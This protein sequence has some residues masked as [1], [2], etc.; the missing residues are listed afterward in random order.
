MLSDLEIEALV[1]I[2]E[3]CGFLDNPTSTVDHG[4]HR[5]VTSIKRLDARLVTED[6]NRLRH[7]AQETSIV[8]FESVAEATRKEITAYIEELELERAKVFDVA[9]QFIDSVSSDAWII[10]CR[11][12]ERAYAI[13]NQAEELASRKVL[14]ALDNIYCSV[15]ERELR[16]SLS[17]LS[18]CLGRG[19]LILRPDLLDIVDAANGIGRD[20]KR[21]SP[22][23]ILQQKRA[24]NHPNED[25]VPDVSVVGSTSIWDA[26][27]RYE[28]SLKSQEADSVT[29]LTKILIVGPQ[30][31]GKT[32]VCDRAEDLLK[33]SCA[34]M[35]EAYCYLLSN[36]DLLRTHLLLDNSHP[37]Q[38]TS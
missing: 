7:E 18:V 8:E 5:L 33:D 2:L 3:L 24:S 28:T 11:A 12:L 4:R 17:A 14:K 10:S 27:K 38:S 15:E 35:N 26:V 21:A 1:E 25:V 13:Q 29:R 6:D 22:R 30:G 31:S 37:S 36:L 34:G 23:A 32:H 16:E 19:D 9:K 20:A